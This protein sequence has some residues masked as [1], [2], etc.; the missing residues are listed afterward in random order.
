MEQEAA[1]RVGV[2]FQMDSNAGPRISASGTM[3]GLLWDAETYDIPQEWTQFSVEAP[4]PLNLLLS[5]KSVEQDLMNAFDAVLI[6]PLVGLRRALWVPIERGGQLV[7]V[8]LL[9]TRGRQNSIP[10][11]RAES[12]AAELEL[13]IHH[14][15]EVQQVRA[16]KTD[17]A[18]A[19]RLFGVCAV[20]GH[21]EASLQDLAEGCTK[22]GA[23]NSGPGAMFAVIG[24]SRHEKEKS[25]G[26]FTTEFLWKSG[27]AEWTRAIEKPPLENL[28]RKALE[29]RRVI[30]GEPPGAWTQELVARIAAF[31]LESEGEVLGMLVA[32]LSTEAATLANLERLEWRAT[33]AA[34]LL[35]KMRSNAAELH[36]SEWQQA[37][38]DSSREPMV[39]VDQNGGIVSVSRGA[40]ERVEKWLQAVLKGRLT[41]SPPRVPVGRTAK[42]I[43]RAPARRRHLT[44]ELLAGRTF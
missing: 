4:L 27:D 9:G 38:L 30:G 21:I 10:A 25:S 1:D 36:F 34:A 13:A 24:V 3:R 40:R 2:W 19:R 31:P 43:E 5:G 32:G 44:D 35:K 20:G 22:S 29:E 12:V 26:E 14:Q 11:A 18:L 16:T 23:D 33:L 7:G 17:I 41:A 42:R 6:G 15:E 39:V 37:F 8:I 28:W